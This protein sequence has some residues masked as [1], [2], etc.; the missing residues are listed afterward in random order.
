MILLR[1]NRSLACRPVAYQILKEEC[2]QWKLR[3]N[4]QF[5]SDAVST[6]KCAALLND[7]NLSVMTYLGSLRE[8]NLD[9][10][11]NPDMWYRV[12]KTLVTYIAQ[13]AVNFCY[14]RI[15]TIV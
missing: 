13:Y 1:W 10:V 2:E 3:V 14:E 11:H 6:G 8:L 9:H 5:V 4:F 12:E 15:L 7:Q